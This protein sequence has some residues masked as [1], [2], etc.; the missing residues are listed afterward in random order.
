MKMKYRYL[1]LL[2]CLLLFLPAGAGMD[3]KAIYD[4]TTGETGE[5]I[6]QN[7][8]YYFNSDS[9]SGCI[10]AG[11]IKGS[12]KEVS[13]DD[14]VERI[15]FLTNSSNLE[16]YPVWTP[17]GNYILYTVK[18]NKSTNSESYRMKADGS[19]IER[20]GIGEGNLTGFSDISPDGTLLLTK[21][22]DSKPGL[23]LANL[24]SGI[25]TPVT[26][27][28]NIS[29][30]W[31]AWCRLGRK[32][33]YTRESG[34]SPSQLWVTDKDG[35][36]KM[37]LGNS[38]N[39]G[40][41]KDWCPLGQ[42]IIYSVKNSKEKDD[43]WVI[44]RNG[45]N[46]TQLTNTPYGEWNPSFSPD[47][48]K[49]VYVSDEGGKPEIWIRDI[50]GNYK[51]KLTNNIGITEDSNPKWSP[52]GLELVFAAHNLINN[53]ENLTRNNSSDTGLIN[54]STNPTISGSSDSVTNSSDI[55]VIKLVPAFAVPP[56]PKITDV[57]IDFIRKFPGEGT[58]NI[59]ITVKNEGG[60]SSKGYIWVSFP[61]GKKI[62]NIEGTGSNITV[63]PEGS[64]IPGKGG[65]IPANYPLIELV[66]DKWSRGQEETLNITAASYNETDEIAFFVR[67]A[68]KNDFTR[69]YSKDPM[70]SS[71]IDQQGLKVYRY[72]MPVF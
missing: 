37:R 64:M 8:S 20:I 62:E 52:D 32:I 61:D 46:Q 45:T 68:L 22:I 15:A 10:A 41:G 39:I 57:K 56:L 65:E 48:K 13:A 24:E 38:Y 53:S 58:A 18:G 9:G 49:M 29:G 60:N 14:L 7:A 50:E 43:L 34:S 1:S 27:D 30:S 36:G 44:G 71:D 11:E 59:S 69:N 17:D 12:G 6:T 19:E 35:T 67:S 25:V 72:S 70:I 47:G 4:N 26:G 23:Y 33:V 28:Q 31:G 66:E 63:Y 42:K 5:N 16:L 51:A 21:S 54:Y 40:I 2:L 3:N 55:A